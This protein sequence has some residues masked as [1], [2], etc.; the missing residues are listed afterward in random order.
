[1]VKVAADN[2]LDRIQ[3]LL[4]K[5][6]SP[7]VTEQEA[8]SFRD[9]AF[10]LAAKYR[11]D[12]AELKAKG[13][14]PSEKIV[15]RRMHVSRPFTQMMRLALIVFESNDCSLIRISGTKDTIHAFGYENDMAKAELLFTSL[16]VQGARW[17]AQDYREYRYESEER[18][19]T[20]RRGWWTGYANKVYKR[21]QAIQQRAE[22]ESATPG[23]AIVLR[24]RKQDTNTAMVNHYSG[25][26][27]RGRR[28]KGVSSHGG[29]RRG[30]EAGDR[31]DLG[32]TRMG[33][34]ARGELG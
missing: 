11:I 16:L 13:Q 9:K 20:F 32:G 33:P 12:H 10:E 17:C 2:A 31:A 34:S 25:A 15:N 28:T 5:A 18:R 24:D 1:V 19:S 6:E 30:S 7:A 14:A 3:K 23:T 26:I 29:Y 21:L 22:S 27:S 8:E 4:A